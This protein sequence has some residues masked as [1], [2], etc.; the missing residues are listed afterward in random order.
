MPAGHVLLCNDVTDI[1]TRRSEE[2]H[3]WDVVD[4]DEGVAY[5]LGTITSRD[6]LFS[7]LPAIGLIMCEE[8]DE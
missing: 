8:S 7:A 3:D 5:R 2:L 4:W 1:D 6:D